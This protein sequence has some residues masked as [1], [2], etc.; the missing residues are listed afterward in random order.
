[1]QRDENGQAKSARLSVPSVSVN[2]RREPYFTKI[3]A[4]KSAR[5][6]T[7]ST[8]RGV[9]SRDLSTTAVKKSDKKRNRRGIDGYAILLQ[10]EP[11]SR[12]SVDNFGR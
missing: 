6:F 2:N 8:L 10:R 11:A 5:W 4:Q 9:L 7:H 1:M 12:S 3:I